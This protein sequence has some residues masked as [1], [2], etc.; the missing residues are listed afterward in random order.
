M[1]IGKGPY[2]SH[3]DKLAKLSEN[4]RRMLGWFWL[5]HTGFLG[6]KPPK[7][8]PLFNLNFLLYGMTVEKSV[9]KNERTDQT[10]GGSWVE[11]LEDVECGM[12][13]YH[14]EPGTNRSSIGADGEC[15]APDTE[16]QTPGP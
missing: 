10:S 12:G 8:Q 5:F 2:H 1:L 6:R 13:E 11:I 7:Y 16:G 4:D 3:R 14:V 9:K 15:A